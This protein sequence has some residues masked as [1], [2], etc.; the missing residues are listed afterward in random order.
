MA[1]TKNYSGGCHCGQVR[2]D[3]TA[4][5]SQV[6]ACNCSICTKR[7]ALWVFVSPDHFAL[8]AGTDD[9]A[10]Y[11]FHKKKIHH[12]FCRE[13]GVGA[14]SRGETPEGAE[15][16]AINVCCLGGVDIATLPT[17]PFDGKNI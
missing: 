6:M 3:V 2:F 16:I 8:R 1:D 10:D 17:I 11:Q 13:C 12:L 15:M 5:L 9:L 14:F 4:E 7:G